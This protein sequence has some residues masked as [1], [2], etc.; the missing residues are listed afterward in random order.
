MCREMIP[1]SRFLAD[2]LGYHSIRRLGP[3]FSQV[4]EYYAIGGDWISGS[5][6]AVDATSP[7]LDVAPVKIFDGVCH[8]KAMCD[9]FET[10]DVRVFEYIRT[11][12]TPKL[13]P[14]DSQPT[15]AHMPLFNSTVTAVG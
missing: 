13:G 4:P 12:F 14:F 5:D 2:E 8:V 15:Y 6:G 3:S 11:L 10:G 9:R 1:N 7:G